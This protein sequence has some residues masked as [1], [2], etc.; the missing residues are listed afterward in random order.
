[1]VMPPKVYVL[2]QLQFRVLSVFNFDSSSSNFNVERGR[3]KLIMVPIMR[4]K[5]DD[6][7]Y[8]YRPQQE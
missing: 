6:G 5:K 4:V 8:E 1:M 7:S 2:D 3:F